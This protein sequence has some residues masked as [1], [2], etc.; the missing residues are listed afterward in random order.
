MR[1]LVVFAVFA[2]TGLA[3]AQECPLGPK[4]TKLTIQRVMINFGKLTMKAEAVTRDQAGTDEQIA[5]AVT[6]LQ[7]AAACAQA[8]VDSNDEDMMPDKAMRLTG[9]E[10]EQFIT[11]FKQAMAGFKAVIDSFAA[12]LTRRDFTDAQVQR[13]MMNDIADEAHSRF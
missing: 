4:D 9:A 7:T 13:K 1:A 5:A 10:R 12:A 11:Q 6:D 2:L 3:Q 8:S